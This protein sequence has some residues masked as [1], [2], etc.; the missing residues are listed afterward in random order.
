MIV[1]RFHATT[2]GLLRIFGR[3]RLLLLSS[4]CSFSRKLLIGI[5]W[6]RP[7]PY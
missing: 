7:P 6:S 1:S 2:V 4:A 5:S 3:V